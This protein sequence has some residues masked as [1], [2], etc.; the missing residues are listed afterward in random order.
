[1]SLQRHP[2][3]SRKSS[4]NISPMIHPQFTNIN[5]GIFGMDPYFQIK[6]PQRFPPKKH[7]FR[8]QL[9]NCS[10]S[11]C[12]GSICGIWALFAEPQGGQ[13]AKNG[14]WFTMVFTHSWSSMYGKWLVG[15]LEHFLFFHTLGTITPTDFHIFQ[16]GR[17]TTKQMDNDPISWK[18]HPWHHCRSWMTLDFQMTSLLLHRHAQ[19]S[20]KIPQ[21]PAGSLD[22]VLRI[23]V[24][25]SVQRSDV[26]VAVSR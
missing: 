5:H 6:H 26:V 3:H 13:F 20:R 11:R 8:P 1:V 10:R 4:S 19:T 2:V 18:P 14:G 25:V 17:Y 7:G 24:G 16:R 9:H 22:L 12:H 15:G 21:V 23:R